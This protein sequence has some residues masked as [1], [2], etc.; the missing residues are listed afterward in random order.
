MRPQVLKENHD[1]LQAGYLESEE[2]HARIFKYYYWPGLYPEVIK[3]VKDCKICQR[4]ILSKQAKIGLRGKRLIE[5]VMGPL[6][7]SKKGKNQ[8]ILVF[9]DLFTKWVEIIPIKKANGKTI[10]SY[11][12]G[13]LREFFIR[14]TVQN[15]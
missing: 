4:T 7:L 11:R 12:L 1:G 13:E 2:T 9:V 5:D 10:E 14:T 6:P 15:S 3:Y 8:Y